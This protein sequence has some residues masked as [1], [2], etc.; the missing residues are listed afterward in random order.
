MEASYRLYVEDDAAQLA[1]LFYRNHFYLGKTG[2]LLEPQEYI[3]I[4][5]RRG[6]LFAIVAELEGEII[7]HVGV[8]PAGC[9]RVAGPKEVFMD[10]FL[11]DK[12]YRTRIHSLFVMYTRVLFHL[13]EFYPNVRVMISEVNFVNKESMYL[14]RQFGGVLLGDQADIYGQLEL[15]N[16]GPSLLY[17]GAPM[18]RKGQMSE[19]RSALPPTKKSKYTFIEPV[20]EGRFVEKRYNLF[21]EDMTLY[22]DLISENVAG[23]FVD[24]TELCAKIV[25]GGKILLLENGS[26]DEIRVH[27]DFLKKEYRM[28]EPEFQDILKTDAE[29]RDYVLGAGKALKVEIPYGMRSAEIGTDRSEYA[30]ALPVVHEEVKESRSISL[31]SDGIFTLDV[32]TGILHTE[33]GKKLFEE[34][35][36]CL[37]IPYL[38]GWITPDRCKV[39]KVTEEK[40]QSCTVVQVRDDYDVL[41]EYKANGD[42][43]KIHTKGFIKDESAVIDPQFHIILDDL[44]GKVDFFENGNLIHSK[45]CDYDRDVKT[46]IAEMLFLDLLKEPYSKAVLSSVTFDFDGEV[47]EI[48]ADRPFTAFYQHNYLA[49]NYIPGD[50]ENGTEGFVREGSE[51]DFGT[52]TIRRR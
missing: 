37:S 7:A 40:D 23:G 15:Y 18:V 16:F 31:G 47:W 9:Q 10:S 51:V 26:D 20:S 27:V 32:D 28:V 21:G 52:L 4:Q 19:V 11:I 33:S 22:L 34:Q 25:P 14:Q 49:V 43:I 46:T 3:D 42:C 17:L 38:T 2:K 36:P 44:E 24:S 8:Y 45:V 5:K 1:Q 39:M 13:Y 48:T 29:G 50:P 6:L 35:W 30:F 12:K 41:R